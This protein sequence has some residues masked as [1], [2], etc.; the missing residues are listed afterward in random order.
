MAKFR[1]GHGAE[2]KR[3]GKPNLMGR[4]IVLTIILA[5]MLIITVF[6]IKHQYFNREYGKTPGDEIFFTQRGTDITIPAERF[7]LPNSPGGN[8][9]HYSYYSFSCKDKC[10]RI[11]WLAYVLSRDNF[12]EEKTVI[13]SP[14]PSK[15]AP[16]SKEGQTGSDSFVKTSLIPDEFMSFNELAAKENSI[17]PI[18]ILMNKYLKNGLWKQLTGHIRNWTME[19]QKLYIVS[20]TIEN[21]NQKPLSNNNQTIVPNQVYTLIL[22]IHTEPY[23]GIA[24]LLS[25]NNYITS[26]F[27]NAVSIDSIE[28]LTG[29]RFFENL[30][31]L[32]ELSKIKTSVDIDNWIS[33]K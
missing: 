21:V 28:K 18:M 32:E 8:L 1:R 3:G 25:N 15:E 22:D 31:T 24:F 29:I 12:S 20:G 17:S 16:P 6:L 14:D 4:T 26:L 19:S 33:Y 5:G 23:N 27:E 7:W 2:T 9:T 11:D 10:S 30:M 13:N